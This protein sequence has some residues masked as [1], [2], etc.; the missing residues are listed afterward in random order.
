MIDT[1]IIPE[2]TAEGLCYARDIFRG[3]WSEGGVAAVCLPIV[4]AEKALAE[5]GWRRGTGRR[6]P[7]PWTSPSGHREWDTGDAL[8]MAI[9]AETQ[10]AGANA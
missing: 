7:G 9:T 2:T 3:D 4:V 6:G 8:A 1:N 5:R 10:T